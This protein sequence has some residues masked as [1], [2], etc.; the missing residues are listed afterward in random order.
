VTQPTATQPVQ[1]RSTEQAVVPTKVNFLGTYLG[2]ASTNAVGP[3]PGLKP[4]GK[5]DAV[6]GLDIE[7]FP[8]N[9]ITGIEISPIEGT[10]IRW[11]TTGAPD[12]WG[13]AVAYQSAATAILNRPDGSVRIPIDGRA[14]FYLYVADPGDITSTYHRMRIIVYLADGSAYQ[15]IVRKPGATTTTVVPGQEEPTKAK[16][17]ITCEFRGFIAD[18]VNASNRPGKSG[19]LNATLVLKMEVE[20][21]KL[22]KVVMSGSDGV[23]HWSSDGKPGTMFLGVTRYPQIYR[24]IN[25]KGVLMQQPVTGRRTFYLYAADNGM[26]TNPSSRLTVTVTFT[27]KS[28]LTTEVS[29]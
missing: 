7:I 6:F 24:L 21:K 12:T 28:T 4:G 23:V 17:L 26:L 11:S 9:F 1:E 8:K 14:Q 2:F 13:L 15:Q 3:Y 25:E 16:G 20:N 5:P 10:G 27:D 19:Y 18:L 29:K 22:A